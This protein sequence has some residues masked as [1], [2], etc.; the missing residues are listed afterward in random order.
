MPIEADFHLASGR[1]IKQAAFEAPRLFHGR[2][3]I[4]RIVITDPTNPASRTVMRFLDFQPQVI[5]DKV[6]NLARE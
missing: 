1:L 2:T 6:F 4:S 5:D 3:V